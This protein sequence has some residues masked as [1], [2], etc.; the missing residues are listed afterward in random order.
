MP[1]VER[2]PAAIGLGERASAPTADASWCGGAGS[3]Q[4]DRRIFFRPLGK[5]CSL[6]DGWRLALSLAGD[7]AA[8]PLGFTLRALWRRFVG[9]KVRLLV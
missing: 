3:R 8:N 7:P 5:S 9:H 4:A 2:L 1:S 6:Q